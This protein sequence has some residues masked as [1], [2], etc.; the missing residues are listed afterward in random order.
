MPKTWAVLWAVFGDA[1]EPI[2]VDMTEEAAREL[3]DR[4]TAE[5]RND[6]YAEDIDSGRTYEG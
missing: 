4:L 3:V 1:S 5:G 2:G 6:V